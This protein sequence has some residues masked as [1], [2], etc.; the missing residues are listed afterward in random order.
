M[1]VLLYALA[2]AAG[3]SSTARAG[4]LGVTDL[5]RIHTEYEANQARW[6]SEFMDKTFSATL[7]IDGV[8]N[9]LSNKSFNVT[10]KASVSDWMPSVACQDVP[11]SDFLIAKNKGDV[12]F[13]RGTVK[14]HSFGILM[15]DKCEFFDSEGAAPSA[16]L[17]QPKIEPVLKWALSEKIR[18][19]MEATGR[20]CQTITDYVWISP[21]HISIVCDRTFRE[22]FV[23][24]ERGWRIA[25]AWE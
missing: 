25:R 21:S 13:F 9:I 20:H 6:S 19:V 18:K 10:F 17:Q 22:A 5:S 1:K 15:L 11:P 7:A 4:D 23:R 24:D 14:D 2:L 3:A 12:I 8:K 16:A